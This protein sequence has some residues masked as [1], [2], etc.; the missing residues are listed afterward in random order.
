MRGLVLFVKI[1]QKVKK[2]IKVFTLALNKILENKRIQ[3]IKQLNLEKILLFEFENYNL[4]FEFFSKNNIILTDK[5]NKIINQLFRETWKDREIKRNAI[6]STPKNINSILEYNPKKNDFDEKKNIISN[7]IK[8]INLHPKIIEAYLEKN[9]IKNN[10][11]NTFEKTINFFKKEFEKN[12]F[13]KLKGIEIDDKFIPVNLNLNFLID[14]DFNLN[15]LLNKSFEK[16]IFKNKN[17]GL[18][19]I[20]KKKRMWI[21]Y[22]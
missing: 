13:L 5:E 17:L 4:Y 8:N 16:I 22:Y 3:N 15:Q 12:D 18:K 11:Y 1:I 14:C 6:Y 10:D 21:K 9:N 2:K 7:I 19:E 20:E